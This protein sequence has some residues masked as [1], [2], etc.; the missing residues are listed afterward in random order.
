[1]TGLTTKLCKPLR[2]SLLP[3]SLFTLS[4]AQISSRLR[5]HAKMHNHP[6]L[7]DFY[8]RIANGLINFEAQI[9]QLPHNLFDV[10]QAIKA[11]I[12][13]E[14]TPVKNKVLERH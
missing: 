12:K 1:M 6:D 3:V 13:K 11:V 5:N 9:H 4:L 10:I 14:Y 7:Y 8:E 2:R